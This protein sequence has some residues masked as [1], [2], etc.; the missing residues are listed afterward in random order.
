MLLGS[1]GL[2]P[3]QMAAENLP[4]FEAVPIGLTEYKFEFLIH[5]LGFAT[6]EGNS[7]YNDL[8]FCGSGRA[9]CFDFH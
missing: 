4:C 9:G 2:T 1:K 3:F 8:I 7:Q 5:F 6:K